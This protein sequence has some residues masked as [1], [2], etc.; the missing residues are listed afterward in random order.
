MHHVITVYDS[1]AAR[2]KH[3]SD[4]KRFNKSM[5]TLKKEGFKIEYLDCK[6][7]ADI[8]S[9]EAKELAEKDGFDVLPIAVFMDAVISSGKYVT[10]QDLVDY[11]EVPDGTIDAKRSKPTPLYEEGPPLS[12]DTGD[13]SRR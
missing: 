4:Y 10:D 9:G 8:P 2:K 7:V 3:A 6:S 13:V 1:A 5:E 12:C 11:L